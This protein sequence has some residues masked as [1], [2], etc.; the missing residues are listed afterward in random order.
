[1]S[2]GEYIEATDTELTLIFTFITLR[3][4]NRLYELIYITYR[5]LIMAIA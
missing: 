2:P 1:M 5:I 3:Y 4:V